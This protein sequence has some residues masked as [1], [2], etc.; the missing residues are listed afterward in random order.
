ME[1]IVILST[2]D[3][4]LVLYTDTPLGSCFDLDDSISENPL[5]MICKKLDLFLRASCKKKL[6][7]PLLK[8]AIFKG[9]LGS[10]KMELNS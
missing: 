5:T 10:A 9:G 4:V 1:S 6:H 3:K 2:R 7:L 8:S